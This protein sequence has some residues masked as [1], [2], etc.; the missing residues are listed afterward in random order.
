[1]ALSDA[2]V[3]YYRREPGFRQLWFGTGFNRCH[4][5]DIENNRRLRSAHVRPPPDP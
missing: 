4:G 5:L 1:V 2:F 3:T